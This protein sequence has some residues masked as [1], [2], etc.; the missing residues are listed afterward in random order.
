MQT[1]KTGTEPASMAIEPGEVKNK[2]KSY[3]QFN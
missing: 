2:T 3:L 1:P